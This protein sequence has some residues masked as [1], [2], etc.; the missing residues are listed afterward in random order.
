M[1][2]YLSHGPC[3]LVL[4]MGTRPR[5]LVNEYSARLYFPRFGVTYLIRKVL[6]VN[7]VEADNI[8]HLVSPKS[9]NRRPMP[10]RKFLNYMFLNNITIQAVLEKGLLGVLCGPLVRADTV[11]TCLEARGFFNLTIS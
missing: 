6:W 8:P 11:G 7:R 1:G 5:V 4:P 3:F 9:G 2:T 10:T